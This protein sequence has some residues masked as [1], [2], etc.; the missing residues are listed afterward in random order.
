MRIGVAALQGAFRE[1]VQAFRQL[2]VEAIE[3][4]RPEDLSGLHGLIIPGGE[5]TTIR[6]LM[7][8]FGL[9]VPLKARIR[10]GLPVLGTCAGM[11]LLAQCVDGENGSGLN[12]LDIRVRRNAFGRQV[13]S[14]ET[15]VNVPALGDEPFHAVFIRA[16]I[17]ESVGPGVEVMARLADGRIVAVRQ[18]AVMG[19]AFHPELTADLRLHR[20]FLDLV[21]ADLVATGE[22]LPTSRG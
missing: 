5:S 10:E 19:L 9:D 20:F 7:Q 4:R 11:I 15:E 21:T 14:F 3:V 6:L 13:D 12:G 8:E 16:P 18:G 22:P 17:V 1:H 2:G